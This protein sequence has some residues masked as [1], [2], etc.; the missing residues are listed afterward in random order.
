M[1]ENNKNID[2]E[3]QQTQ[4]TQ[5][6]Y[7]M[8]KPDAVAARNVYKILTR[9]TK[10]GFKIIK[11]KQFVFNNE[12]VTYFYDEHKEKSWFCNLKEFMLSGPCVGIIL[13]HPEAITKW[14]ELIGPT[15][16][17]VAKEKYPN[18]LRALYGDP[19]NTSKNACH[20]SDSKESAKRE[21]E[22]F[23]KQ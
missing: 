2:Q 10:E 17:N 19:T 4:Q 18:C 15:N 6:T 23:L 5:Q 22:F 12:S 7:A 3:V 1:E 16:I 9:I 14:R 21:I 8:I 13:E 20:G 11:I